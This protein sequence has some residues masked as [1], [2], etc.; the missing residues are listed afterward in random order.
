MELVT[1][2]KP[3]AN[4]I[5]EIAMQNNT[6]EEWRDV[7][8]AGTQVVNDESMQSFL[9]SPG[10]TKTNKAIAIS[11][12]LGKILDRNLSAE[13]KSFVDI[14]LENDRAL[15][16]PSILSL[17]EKSINTLSDSK[18]FQVISAYKLSDKEKKQIV[19]DL[20]DKYTANVSIET[21]V[22]ESLVGG[23][24]IKDGDKVIDLSI[25][26]RVSELNLQLS[27]N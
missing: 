27:I 12:L 14:L 4:A 11:S 6:H 10:E 19:S 9:A 7:L 20:A 22:D 13:E 15:V 23:V 5:I 26:A 2:A 17:F 8:M 1:I 16:L 24:V 18:V 3:Y 25:K 21:F